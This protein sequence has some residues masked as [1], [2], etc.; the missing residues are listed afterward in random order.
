MNK[1]AIV[2]FL[3]VGALILLSSCAQKQA[4]EI[5]PIPSISD[6][7][8]QS[9]WVW[10]ATTLNS[11]DA[12][13]EDLRVFNMK[14]VFLSTGYTVEKGDEEEGKEEPKIYQNYLKAFSKRYNN[15]IKEANRNGISVEALY[16]ESEWARRINRDALIY[17][18]NIV[19]KYNKSHK[20]RFSALQL[21]IE[22]HDLGKDWEDNP[23]ELLDQLYENLK[24]VKNLIDTHNKQN[25]D[26]LKL[27]SVIPP[28]YSD[29][30]KFSIKY[31]N[32]RINVVDALLKV[33]DG[34]AIMDYTQDKDLYASWGVEVLK[35]A[36]KYDGK[37]VI[38]GAEFQPDFPDVCLYK[39]SWEEVVDYF[40]Y[41]C[42]KFKEHN[43]FAGIGIHKYK[44]YKGYVEKT[45]K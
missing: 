3:S 39:M 9:I 2:L 45:F 6:S 14:S 37:K 38:I 28:W 42:G 44:S 31:D 10:D 17:E 35:I 16:G 24:D 27:I 40:S 19:L 36:D 29:Y 23:N 30:K 12:L 22:P 20:N 4:V 21:D 43:S 33:V 25:N 8:Q 41:G 5:K 15:F 11:P 26:N 7:V 18:V 34:I 13:L 32:N 1:K